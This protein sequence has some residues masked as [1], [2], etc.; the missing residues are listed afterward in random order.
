MQRRPLKGI[1]EL[2]QL[3][4]EGLAALSPIAVRWPF[5][6]RGLAVVPD[7]L[8]A[9]TERRPTTEKALRIWR[10]ENRWM[11]LDPIGTYFVESRL[12]W[13]ISVV[14]ALLAVP[15]Y[16][17]RGPWTL[18]HWVLV[19]SWGDY[20]LC[21]WRIQLESWAAWYEAGVE[22]GRHGAFAV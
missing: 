5:S 10:T 14:H 15:V 11:E 9:E 19:A 16:A 22:D 7:V 6:R 2:S 13:S 18:S 1:V 3:L 17:Q 21:V 4:D 20:G 8:T 12:I